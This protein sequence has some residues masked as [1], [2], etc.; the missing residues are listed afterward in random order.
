MCC[1]GQFLE[2]VIDHTA[3]KSFFSN[4]QVTNV[5]PCLSFSTEYRHTVVTG[6]FFGLYRLTVGLF[7]GYYFPSK[8]TV[9]FPANCEALPLD[10]LLTTNRLFFVAPP[11]SSRVVGCSF[12]FCQVALTSIS[13]SFLPLLSSCY[14]AFRQIMGRSFLICQVAPSCS[15]VMFLPSKSDSGSFLP[16]SLYRHFLC[17]ISC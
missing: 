6:S 1:S 17:R 12:L 9:T 15:V 5:V 10:S 3:R 16:H 13:A 8:C 2:L 11:F 14:F 4:E 7:V